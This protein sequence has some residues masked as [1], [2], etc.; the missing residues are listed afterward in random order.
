MAFAF[1]KKSGSGKVY[2]FIESAIAVGVKSN[3]NAPKRNNGGIGSFSG[4]GT[5]SATGIEC[6]IVQYSQFRFENPV[7]MSEQLNLESNPTSFPQIANA[8]RRGGWIGFWLQVG[9]GVVPVFLILFALFL[10]P[11]KNRLGQSFVG[12][13]L[14]YACLIALGFTIYWCFRY[15]QIGNQLDDPQRRP[16]KASVTRTLWI[17]LS[18]NIVGM[19]CAVV[20]ALWKVGV[21][22]FKML[23]V[24][25][26][27]AMIDNSGG[28]PTIVSRS[29]PI[30]VPMDLIALQAAVNAIAAELVGIIVAAF[31]L[32]MVTQNSGK[33]S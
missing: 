16:T 15:T 2:Q 32:Y 28:G 31:L 22:L 6:P 24:P 4:P 10:S 14:A 1:V 25:P 17:G 33:R 27:A 8:F 13:I 11:A 18:A 20:V 30:I 3:P 9:F 23:S 19:S 26:G 29:G 7:A 12:V 21:L 5:P